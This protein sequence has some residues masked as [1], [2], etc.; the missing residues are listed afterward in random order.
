MEEDWRLSSNDGWFFAPR[1]LLELGHGE[2]DVHDFLE[3]VG[4]GEVEVLVV[5]LFEIQADG[6]SA[7]PGS[8]EAKDESRA[9]LE[10]E[11]PPLVG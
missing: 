6:G 10:N 7:G 3:R 2:G 5:E 1:V 9:V 11:S 8:G 4:S